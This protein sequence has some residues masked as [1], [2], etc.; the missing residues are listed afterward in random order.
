MDSLTAAQRSARMSR[1]RGSDT[2]PELRFATQLSKTRFAFKRNEVS[3]LGKPDFVFPKY[4]VA[5]F[6]HGCFWHA[7]ECQKGRIPGSNG[8]FWSDKF[9]RNK[10]RDRR[11]ARK[12]R[13]LGWSV[14]TVWECRIKTDVACAREANRVVS[15]LQIRRR[16][17]RVVRSR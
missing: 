16:A 1:I 3:L 9:L 13:L 17:L 8:K 15:R 2:K 5:V 4:K 14:L 7:H 12:L 10:Q 11:V 6:V